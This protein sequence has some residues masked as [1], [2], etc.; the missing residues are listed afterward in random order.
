MSEVYEYEQAIELMRSGEKM[1]SIEWSKHH[2]YISIINVR[3]VEM[4]AIPLDRYNNQLRNERGWVM[5]S[6]D[7]KF[8]LDLAPPPVPPTVETEV[9]GADVG[10]EALPLPEPNPPADPASAAA[11]PAAEPAPAE[12]GPDHTP[13]PPE[14]APEPA[15]PIGVEAA[16]ALTAVDD[17][18]RVLEAAT[19]RETERTAL[20]QATQAGELPVAGDE[21]IEPPVA[22]IPP[23]EPIA[24]LTATQSPAKA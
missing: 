3:G 24:D 9:L 7:L 10:A 6:P 13:P 11:A 4:I 14:A 15:Q 20:E 5:W 8:P 18:Q 23:A 17:A 21:P 2:G 12:P 19:A 16:A 22:T 1:T